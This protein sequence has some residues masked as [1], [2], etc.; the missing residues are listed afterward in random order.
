ME[1]E[2]DFDNIDINSIKVVDL[3]LAS[4]ILMD[5]YPKKMRWSDVDKLVDYPIPF[6]AISEFMREYEK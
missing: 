6:N 4:S 1:Y 3:N 2:T 5:I